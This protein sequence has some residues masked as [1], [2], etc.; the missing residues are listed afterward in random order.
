MP[1]GGARLRP[2][3]GQNRLASWGLEHPFWINQ[4][5][6]VSLNVVSVYVVWRRNLQKQY[7]H[8]NTLPLNITTLIASSMENYSEVSLIQFNYIY[9]QE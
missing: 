6:K 2:P 5:L 3:V 7:C 1:Y 4:N 9:Y 8:A